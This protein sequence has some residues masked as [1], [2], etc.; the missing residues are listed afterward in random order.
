MKFYKEDDYIFTIAEL[1]DFR[2]GEHR[3]KDL[4]L[5]CPLNILY[6]YAYLTTRFQIRQTRNLN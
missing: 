1:I 3:I 6:T 5:L 2:E 4:D